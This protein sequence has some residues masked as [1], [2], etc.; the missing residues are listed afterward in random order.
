MGFLVDEPGKPAKTVLALIV[1]PPM[2]QPALFARMIPWFS[3]KFDF[4]F[5]QI[6]QSMKLMYDATFIVYLVPCDNLEY[7]LKMFFKK[8]WLSKYLFR[9]TSNG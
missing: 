6:I 9:T 1:A 7:M 5:N 4:L 2:G 3:L 8:I